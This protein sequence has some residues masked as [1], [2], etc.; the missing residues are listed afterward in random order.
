MSAIAGLANFEGAKIPGGVVEGMTAAMASRGPDGR[1][2]RHA[3]G[4]ALGHC[5][6][7]STAVMRAEAQPATSADSSLLTVLDGCVD[8]RDGLAADLRS[9]GFAPQAPGDA[10]LVLRAYEAWGEE[11]AARI[12]GEF[13]FVIWDSRRRTLFGARDPAGTRYFYYHAA[14]EAFVFA[15]EIRGV[16]AS[17]KVRPRLNEDRLLDYIVTEFDRDDEVGTFY[18]DIVR[19]PAGHALLVSRDGLRTWRY[20]DPATLPENRFASLDECAEAFGEVMRSAV[21]SRL[22]ASGPIGAM[23]SGGLDSSSIVGVIRK[24]MRDRLGE[25]LRTFSLVRENQRSCPEW[26]AVERMIAGGWVV[27]TVLRPSVADRAW[28]ARIDS[29][30]GMNEPFAFTDGYTDALLCAAARD[31]GCRVLMDG[32]AGD[33]FFYSYGR[34]LGWSRERVL[35]LPAVM[36]AACRHRVEGRWRSL[37]RS[38][39]SPVAPAPLRA[40]Y[41]RVRP[42]PPDPQVSLLRPTVARDFMHDRLARRADVR[43]AAPGDDRRVHARNFTSGLLSFAHEVNGQ[44]ALSSGIEPRSPYSDR[45]V[46]EFAVRMPVGAKLFAGWYKLM[47]RTAM[48]GTLP[49]E[50]RWRS[51]VGM[52]PGPDFRR[53]LIARIGR[54][55]PDFWNRPYVERKLESWIDP[56]R[57]RAAWSAHERN[58]DLQVGLNLLALAGLA[59]WIEARF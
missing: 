23:L 26:K 31:Q 38:L 6:L 58:G 53:Q 36:A 29:I 2:H 30:P 5:L 52:H 48:R 21:A 4:I 17:A 3:S 35:R 47:L 25:P 13:A 39:L 20:W 19:L 55:A 12:I 10:H 11:C 57:L 49:E 37:A 32:M 41:R 28:R 18:R 56:E 33:L 27:P 54:G 44:L 34:S 59:R 22:D 16:L 9:A 51:D 8:D 50:V 14:P 15:S 42:A 7:A 24:D 45:R 40:A 43:G 1:A 46:I